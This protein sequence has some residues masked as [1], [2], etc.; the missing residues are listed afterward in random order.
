MLSQKWAAVVTT[1]NLPAGQQKRPSLV[2]RSLSEGVGHETEKDPKIHLSKGEFILWGVEAVVS[3]TEA[4][5][6]NFL[7][8]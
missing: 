3:S 8:R 7:L 2:P 6:L 5:R 1:L 4:V